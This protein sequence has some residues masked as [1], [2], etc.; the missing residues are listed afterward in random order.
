MEI[1]PMRAIGV[2]LDKATLQQTMY[3]L[4]IDRTYDSLTRAQK[5]ELL[6]YQIMTQTTKM[7]GELGRTKR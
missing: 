4:G 6:Y 2:A 7:Q 1:E 5:T 3:S